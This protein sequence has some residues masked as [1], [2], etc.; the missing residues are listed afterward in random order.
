MT[1]AGPIIRFLLARKSLLCFN[2]LFLLPQAEAIR[3]ATGLPMYTGR[4]L[5]LGE[6]GYNL[7]R[8]FNLRE[9]LSAADDTLPGRLTETPQKP[10][11]PGTVVPLKKMLP[12]YYKVRGWDKEGRPTRKKLKSLGIEYGDESK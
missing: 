8:L 2:S 5:K 6:T 10:G 12:L 11:K 3:L 7:E 9:G 1:L 4:F